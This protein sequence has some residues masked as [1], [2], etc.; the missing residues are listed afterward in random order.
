[1][2]FFIDLDGT[3]IDSFKR[4]Y[5]L[6]QELLDSYNVDKK[7]DI[8]EYVKCKR[9]GMNN[10]KY[11]VDVLNIDKEMAKKIKNVWIENIEELKYLDYDIL[12]EDSIDFLSCLKNMESEVYFLTSRSNKKNLMTE[13][14][15]LKLTEYVKDIFVVNP[16]NNENKEDIIYNFKNEDEKIFMIGDSEVDFNAAQKCGI[17]SFIL[18]KG[19]RSDVYLKNIDVC[20]SYNNLYEVMEDIE[21]EKL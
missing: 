21:N 3:I 5:L 6:L 16:K 17:K 10:Y 9:D 8:D 14:E 15:K 13:L 18:N 20:K 7:I 1:M 12:Y 2:K 19:F 11:L 4:H